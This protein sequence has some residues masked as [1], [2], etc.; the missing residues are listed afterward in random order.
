[1]WRVIKLGCAR[2][3]SIK[4]PSVGLL[5]FF[6]FVLS[7]LYL[8]ILPSLLTLVILLACA[9]LIGVTSVACTCLVMPPTL[10]IYD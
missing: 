2:R 3:D 6:S 9:L 1:M 7:V 5:H 10:H 4:R 8:F